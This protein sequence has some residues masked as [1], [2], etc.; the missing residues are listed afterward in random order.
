MS[1]MGA[2]GRWSIRGRI[3]ATLLALLLFTALGAALL[4]GGAVMRP[5]V[6]GAMRE[7]V[8]VAGYIAA[9]VRRATDR[10]ARAAEL[11]EDLGVEITLREEAPRPGRNWVK[12]VGRGRHTVYVERA[13]GSPIH[14]PLGPPRREGAR[15]HHGEDDDGPDRHE[16]DDELEGNDLDVD[17]AVAFLTVRFPE[18]LDRPGQVVALGMV[19][20]VLLA[21]AAALL[22]SR[23]A[24]QPLELASGAMARIAGGELT[25]RLPEVNGEA[26][27]M[28]ASFNEM[29]SRVE[30]LVDA[31]R[32][33]A[34]AQRKLMGAVSHELRT[35]LARMRLQTELLR[36]GGA[37]PKRLDSLDR[38]IAEIDGLVGELVESLRLDR[39]VL[40]LQVEPLDV[41]ALLEACLADGV[42][43][44]RPVTLEVAPDLH[45]R[46]DRKRLTRVLRNLLANVARHT[47]PEAGVLLRASGVDDCVEIEVRDH[48]PGVSAEHLPHLF[49]PFYRAEA[50]RSRSTGGLGLGLM[51]VQQIVQAHGGTVRAENAADGGLRVRVRLPTEGPGAPPAA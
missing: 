16:E 7:R 15:G 9:E 12:R 34:E 19:F 38:Q 6:G 8:E 1:G 36:D 28:A 39:G 45:L 30:D 21:G 29:A 11:A 14:V 22:M 51:L 42:L 49:E 32:R 43:E 41:G 24:T 35:P 27:R 20:I 47:P 10:E 37:E 17:Q 5:L 25:H 50:S 4:T 46:A 2:V 26:G 44:E 3:L 31:E 48:G 18:D 33:Q 40:A 23:W 13:P